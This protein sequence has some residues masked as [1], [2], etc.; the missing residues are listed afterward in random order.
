MF[1][2]YKVTK[3]RLKN[4]KVVGYKAYILA[5]SY[6]DKKLKRPR[7]RYLAYVGKKPVMSLAKARGICKRKG[8]KL[9]DLKRVKGLRIK[10]S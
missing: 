2:S 5:E 1:L 7:Q 10:D 3:H 4:G 6:W 9:E 8:I